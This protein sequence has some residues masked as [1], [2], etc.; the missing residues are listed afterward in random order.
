MGPAKGERNRLVARCVGNRLVSGIP[1]ALHDAAIVIEQLERVDRAA[2][3]SVGVGDGRRVRPAPGP[4]V[5]S[6]GPEVSFL[7]AAA[8]GIEHRRNSF[9]DRNL[10]G[11]EN[12]LAQPDIERLKLRGRIAYPE[13]QHRA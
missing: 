9:V 10:A 5:A 4:I 6:D 11:A 2:A 7:G 12:E 13:R 1:V 3:R 8:A